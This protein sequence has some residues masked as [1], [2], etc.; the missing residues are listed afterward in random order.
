MVFLTIQSYKE[1][2]K[3]LENKLEE[4]IEENEDLKSD[5][6]KFKT[7]IKN[8]QSKIRQLE[9]KTPSRGKMFNIEPEVN[10]GLDVVVTCYD[11]SVQSCGKPI[12]SKGYGITASG[13]DLRGH[14]WES[15]RAIAVDPKVI[16]LGSDVEVIFDNDNYSKYN[17]VYKAVDTGG[18]IKGNKIDFFLGDFNQNKTH[19]SVWDFGKTTAKV[20]IMR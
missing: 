13:F 3:N 17:G 8:Q 4:S 20:K 9:V 16:P 15:A 1:D 12:G 7:E 2:I 5:I 14:S 6:E 19:Q 18:A 11:L 10:E